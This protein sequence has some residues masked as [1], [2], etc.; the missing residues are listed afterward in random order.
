[1]SVERY[2]IFFS[3]L[4]GTQPAQIGASWL[5]RDIDTESA[6][7][8]AHQPGLSLERAV[9]IVAEPRRYGFH[10][11]LRAPFQLAEGVD[12]KA[13]TDLTALLAARFAPVTIP[14]LVLKQISDFVALVPAAPC[15]AIDAIAAACV[16]ATDPLRAPIDRSETRRR[17]AAPLTERQTLLL[18]RWGYPYVM[19]EFQFHMTLAGPLDVSEISEVRPVLEN[20]FKPLIGQSMRVDAL[21]LFHQPGR[22]RSFQRVGIFPLNSHA[23]VIQPSPER[24]SEIA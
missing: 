19:E 4:P 22:D 17:Q 2:A 11:T 12:Q 21:S 8:R 3:P 23:P 13:I 10:A 18:T 5:G 9:R 15:P 6:M 14:S 20:H 16:K 1:M 7:M 24:V